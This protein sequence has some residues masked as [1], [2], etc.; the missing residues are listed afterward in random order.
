MI[1]PFCV[2]FYVR[3][4]GVRTMSKVI[5]GL[6]VASLISFVVLYRV[7]QPAAYFLMPTR[8]WELGAGALIYFLRNSALFNHLIER[9][10]TAIVLA[11]ILLVLF[12]P[13]RAA[14]ATIAG[15]V[16][17]AVLIVGTSSGTF[18]YGSFHAGRWS[19]SAS[20]PTLSTFGTGEFS[21]QPL[22]NRHRRVDGALPGRPSL[23]SCG[24]V[25][26][27][28]RAP[29]PPVGLVEVAPAVDR[30]RCFRV[31]GGVRPDRRNGRAFRT[32]P[33]LGSPFN[34]PAP[35]HIQKTWWQNRETART[36]KSAMS[37]VSSVRDTSTSAWRAKT[38][39][40]GTCT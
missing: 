6:S 3:G 2:W 24:G 35:T 38:V 16:L 36:S 9:I 31:R 32:V 21:D 26:P 33:V 27:S 40:A 7:D 13:F 1:Y 19:I 8:F 34:L 17:T 39:S 30:I 5:L 22:D 37:K 4:S 10:P 29:P 23:S 20:S 25:V 18:A 14:P 12:A 15:V 11:S 28:G